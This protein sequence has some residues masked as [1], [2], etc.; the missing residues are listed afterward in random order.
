MPSKMAK[1]ALAA[2]GVA[3]QKKM[4]K[5]AVLVDQVLMPEKPTQKVEVAAAIEQICLLEKPKQPSEA[6]HGGRRAAAWHSTSMT[7]GRHR[8]R[9]QAQPSALAT[10]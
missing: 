10:P 3:T 9:P 7:P 8:V 1:I 4:R 2:A 5:V 6:R